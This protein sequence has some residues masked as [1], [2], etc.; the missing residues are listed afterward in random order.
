MTFAISACT[1]GRIPKIFAYTGT[2]ITTDSGTAGGLL[3]D[4]YCSKKPLGLRS[5]VDAID[6]FP[7]RKSR[8]TDP[9]QFFSSIVGSNPTVVSPEGHLQPPMQP[10]LDPPVTAARLDRASGSSC[11]TVIG[12]ERRYASSP[13]ET[14]V[15]P[16]RSCNSS[17]RPRLT[18]T[19]VPSWR[20]T[21]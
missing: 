5:T 15:T 16:K 3:P 21:P 4:K 9:P 11:R 18:L 1:T 13:R 12:S 2:A 7:H 8:A 14:A 19:V 6:L 20:R 17:M 10:V